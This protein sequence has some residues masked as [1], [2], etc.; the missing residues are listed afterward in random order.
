MTSS[1]QHLR[2]H[3]Y[4]Q[5]YTGLRFSYDQPGPFR[6]RDIAHSLAM[7][8]RFRGH[9]TEF[10]SVAEHCVLVSYAMQDEGLGNDLCVA[11][12][13]H[14]AHEAYFGDVPSPMK[15][16]CPEVRALEDRIQRAMRSAL[17]PTITDEVY[18]L[19]KPY[20]LR[21]L[22]AEAWA[23]LHPIPEWAEVPGADEPAHPRIRCWQWQIAE[24]AFVARAKDIGLPVD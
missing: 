7:T 24:H 9:C 21:A 16:N 4:I 1:D 6:I 23:V 15:W 2:R 10:L 20:D 14:D 8:P 22:H 11:G 13:L 19:V 5:T 18:D 3:P 12:L 17:T